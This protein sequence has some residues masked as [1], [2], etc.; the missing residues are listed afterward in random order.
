MNK[1]AL[2]RVLGRAMLDSQ[3]AQLLQ[4][5]PNSAAEAAGVT[6]GIDDLALLKS[7]SMAQILAVSNNIAQG[8]SRAAV[9]DQKQQQGGRTRLTDLAAVLDQQQQQGGMR[10]L[11]D[12]A[13]GSGGLQALAA[14]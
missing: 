5:S 11:Q 8:T 1:D 9:L 3:F 10:Q 14:L 12:L 2:A 13:H 7:V 6:L 4:T